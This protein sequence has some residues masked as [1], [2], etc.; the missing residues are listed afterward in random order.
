MD[1]A[2]RLEEDEIENSEPESSVAPLHILLLQTSLPRHIF[3]LRMDRQTFVTPDFFRAF[4]TIIVLVTEFP[5]DIWKTVLC[6]MKKRLQ[7]ALP[8]GL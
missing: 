6:P 4:T 7:V 5:H 1:L 8:A 3:G 2:K